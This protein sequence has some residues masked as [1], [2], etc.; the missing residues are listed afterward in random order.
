VVD[1]CLPNLDVP[2][3]RAHVLVLVIVVF[4]TAYGLA[5]A[6]LLLGVSPEA[7]VATVA[8]V[9]ALVVKASSAVVPLV[10]AM[11]TTPPQSVVEPASP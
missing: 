11:G 8:A 10:V 7:T 9:S 2:K 4:V 6:M 1:T 5:L 3:R